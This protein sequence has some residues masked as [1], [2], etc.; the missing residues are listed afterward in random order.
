MLH[1]VTD[2]SVDMPGGWKESY[3]IHV[4]PIP[5][6]I[7]GRLYY[8]GVDLDDAE[9]YRI[10]REAGLFP[11]TSLPSVGQLVEFYHSIASP[12]DTILSLHVSSRLSG[13][14]NSVVQAARSL[15]DIY[16]IIPFDSGNG[17]AGL[18][19]MCRDARLL[20]RAGAS[21]QE[22]QERLEAIRRSL[23]I[24]L[25]LDT[26][27]FARRSGRINA[28]Q[29]AVAS[30]LS[31]KP[32]IS[33]KEGLL[34]MTEK[35]RT[36]SRALQRVVALIQQVAGERQVNLA[37]VH[38]C[39]PSTADWLARQLQAVCRAKELIVTDLS[40]SVAAHLGP[41]TVGVVV[42]PVD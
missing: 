33:L 14:F 23:H 36:R 21:L 20:E 30:L 1:I 34:D 31:I 16:T 38:S 13:T 12:G 7:G 2:G 11:R 37:V 27:E 25:T 41:G 17:S 3:Q 29:A 22:I 6:Q 28:L 39:D 32:I 15:S 26:L 8:Q 24:V 10:V 40:I 19:Y 5:I 4:V 18:G 42:Y 35:V 9:F